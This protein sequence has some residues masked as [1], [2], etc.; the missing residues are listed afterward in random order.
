MFPVDVS[1]DR[2]TVGV[3]SSAFMQEAEYQRD[4]LLANLGRELGSR[5]IRSLAFR[6]MPQAPAKPKAAPPTPA[7]PERPL[8]SAEE[9]H[10]AAELAKISDPTLREQ[11]GRVF[12]K[13][14]RRYD[15]PR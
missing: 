2:L 1:G 14:L 6:M 3:T 9:A 12:A 10:L 4:T 7:R 5:A 11:V 15:P 8:S 13:A